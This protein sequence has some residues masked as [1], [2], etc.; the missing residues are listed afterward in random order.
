MG[1]HSQCFKKYNRTFII[2]IIQNVFYKLNNVRVG[3][4][5]DVTTFSALIPH[6][7]CSRDGTGCA[8][9]MNNLR[10]MK[11]MNVVFAVGFGS[12]NEQ[13]LISVGLGGFP[14]RDNTFS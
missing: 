3:R 9:F 10:L 6:I 2:D 5:P 1:Y 14:P 8:I 11:R 13:K 12:S 4:K 7:Q